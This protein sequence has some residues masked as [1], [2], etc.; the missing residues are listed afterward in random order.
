MP[1]VFWMSRLK[2]GVR[3]EDYERWLREFDYVR[4]RELKSIVSYRAYRIEGAFL[5][6]EKPYD[7]LE[8]IEVTDL[9]AYRREL[10]EHPAARAI[11]AQWG[12]YLDLVGSL[13]GECIPPGMSRRTG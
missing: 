1:T 13:H 8:V 6:G 4:A 11:A 12:D 10:N 9:E 5:E 3:R 7:Y 2:P